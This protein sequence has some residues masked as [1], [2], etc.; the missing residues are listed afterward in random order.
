[1]AQGLSRDKCLKIAEVTKHQFYHN[2]VRNAKRGKKPSTD[3]KRVID[4]Q[5]ELI[6]H[7]NQ[8][9]TANALRIVEVKKETVSNKLLEK[10]MLLINQNPDLKCGARRMTQK[11]QIMGFEVNHKKVAA[12]MKRLGINGRNK[13]KTSNRSKNYVQYRVLNPT[14]PFTHLQMDIKSHW[15]V[16]ERCQAYTLSVIDTFTREVL[17][18]YTGCSIL[19]TDVRGLWESIIELHLEPAGRAWSEI[20]L[21]IIS[22]NGPQFIAHILKDFFAQN[23]IEQQFTHPYTPEENAYIESFHSSMSSSVDREHL[24]LKDLKGRLNIFY[25]N[26]NNNRTHTSTKGLPP[27]M[28]RKAWDNDLVITCYDKKKAV[29]IRLRHSLC[30]IPGILSQKEHLAKTNRAKRTNRKQQKSGGKTSSANNIRTPVN[31]SSSVA[32][33]TTKKVTKNTLI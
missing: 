23:G 25:E 30:E 16:Q 27:T 18:H 12:M 13:R 9:S 17:G 10:Q 31:T 11:L 14:Q 2:P 6:A 20:K 29:K 4:V 22:D 15:L 33:C 3:V 7:Q 26:Y 32:S 24:H 5:T 8:G 28:F 21:V 19:A 1:M